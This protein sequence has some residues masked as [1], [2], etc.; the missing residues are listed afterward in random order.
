MSFEARKA[1]ANNDASY[2]QLEKDR[3][4]LVRQIAAWISR[5]E[6]LRDSLT[7]Q[8]ERSEV[9]DLVTSLVSTVRGVLKV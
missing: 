4:V 1:L 6:A 5:A 8:T 7:D 9:G 3:E 2:A